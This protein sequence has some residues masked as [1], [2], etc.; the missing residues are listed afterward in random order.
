MAVPSFGDGHS[1]FMGLFLLLVLL[2][3]LV[4]IVLVL[5]L[6]SA[7]QFTYYAKEL[8][9]VLAQLQGDIFICHYKAEP[10]LN[11]QQQR[12]EIPSDGY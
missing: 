7:E 2:S 8:L 1:V 9:T 11:A 6:E 12:M 5:A 10:P 3:T 4:Y